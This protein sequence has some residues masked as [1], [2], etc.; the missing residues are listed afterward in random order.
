MADPKAQ[1]AETGDALSGLALKLK[2]HFKQAYQGQPQ[3]D[4]KDALGKLGKAVEDTF[5]AL[6]NAVA[7]EAVKADVKTVASSLSNALSATFEEV[8]QEL[9]DAFQSKRKEPETP[10]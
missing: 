6:R 1:W 9:R 5:D 2:L 4:L 7:D 10:D 8:G 3:E